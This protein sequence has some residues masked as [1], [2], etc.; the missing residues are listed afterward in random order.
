[1]KLCHF[2]DSAGMCQGHSQEFVRDNGTFLRPHPGIS[3]RATG[4]KWLLHAHR[5]RPQ[6]QLKLYSIINICKSQDCGCA[7]SMTVTRFFFV[8]LLCSWYLVRGTLF[9]VPCSW[10]LV[11]GTLIVVPCL[12]HLVPCFWYL[13]RV[14]WFV[15]P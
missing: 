15:V 4:A 5:Q 1:M 2:S 12:W 10:Y 13:D 9:V 7:L 6:V 11:R 8:T 3:V 14:T